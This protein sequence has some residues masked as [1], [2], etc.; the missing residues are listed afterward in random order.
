[1]NISSVPHDSLVGRLLRWPLSF[2]P[3]ELVVPILQG[4]LKGQ[5]WVVGSSK[6]G[7]WLGSYEYHKRRLFEQLNRGGDTV[8]DIGAHVGFYTLLA[9]LLKSPTG[10]VYAFEPF[11][12]NIRYLKKH[13]ALNCVTN[14]TL[15]EAAVTDTDGFADFQENDSHLEG[16][17]APGGNLRVKTVSLDSLVTGAV[18]AP[19]HFLKVD[20]EGGEFAALT[21]AR[22]TIVHFRPVI[23][24]ATH[25]DG[26]RRD[27]TDLLTSLGYRLSPV[28]G[29][30][31]AL[32]D[33]I[34]AWHPKNAPRISAS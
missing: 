27:C 7:C 16:R 1:M 11:P 9:S 24:L 17:V 6:H 34:I 20:A 21:G 31:S 5:K 30:N 4:K 13:L 26:P 18:I 28:P 12:R 22:E 23:L 2:I 19:P 8:Y 3:P 33:E 29:T 10:K 32:L 25:G 15:F 14:V